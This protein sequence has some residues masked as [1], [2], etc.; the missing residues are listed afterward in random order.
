MAG[1]PIFDREGNV[2][3]A[4]SAS[5]FYKPEEDYHALGRAVKKKAEEIS[6]LLGYL[7]KRPE[8]E[9]KLAVYPVDKIC[10]ND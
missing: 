9:E 4:I 2:L 10:G 1:A 6:R 7:G 8:K 5:S 3:G